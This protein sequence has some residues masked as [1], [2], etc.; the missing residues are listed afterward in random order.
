MEYGSLKPE[1]GPDDV[2]PSD[3]GTHTGTFQQWQN[4]RPDPSSFP[5]VALAKE[6]REGSS[7]KPTENLLK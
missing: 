1:Q 7:V 5:S 4:L 3:Q 6:E 2:G